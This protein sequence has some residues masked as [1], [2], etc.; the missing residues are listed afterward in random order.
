MK[1]GR[2][3]FIGLL[4]CIAAAGG[5][6]RLKNLGRCSYWVDETNALFAAQSLMKNG[7]MVFPSGFVY[8]RAPLYTLAAAASYACFGVNEAATRL[9]AALFGILSIFMAYFTAAKL[10][11]KKTGLMTAFLV[12]FCHFEVGWSRI[13]KMYTLL[14]FLSLFAVYAFA[15]GFE[16]TDGGTESRP[17]PSVLGRFFNAWGLSPL[18]LAAC[19]LALALAYWTHSLAVFLAAG[20]VVYLLG[21]AVVKGFPSGGKGPNFKAA[22]KYAVFS[23]LTLAAA[24]AGLAA[25]PAAREKAFYFMRYT[26]A[27]AE[28]GSSAQNRQAL[29]DFL[30]SPERFPLAAFFFIGSVFMVS[31]RAGSGWIGWCPLAVAFTALTFVF[32]HRT[33]TYLF[34]VYPFFLAT[35]AYGFT[36]LASG[37]TEAWNRGRRKPGR[38]FARVPA[39][40]LFSVFLASPWLRITLHIPFFPDGHTNMAVTPEEWREASKT[41]LGLKRPGDLVVTSLPQAALAYGLESDYCLNWADLALTRVEEIMTKDGRPADIYAGV[42]CVLTPEEWEALVMS[43]GRGWLVLSRFH[44]E[45][46]NYIPASVKAFIQSRLGAPMRTSNETVLVYHWNRGD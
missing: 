46:E 40:L 8:D 21:A 24:A 45:N 7:T 2:I 35:A 1:R 12:A 14:Q 28:G 43:H 4:V 20:F 11:D 34:F 39:V 37:E 31:R 38:V 33:P 18:W 13:A 9:P 22:R 29:F 27:W 5:F 25:F 6:L 26:P 36:V 32:T 10:F 23:A 30:I 3:V 16:P 41:V 19:F 42:P 17:S 15:R 44:L